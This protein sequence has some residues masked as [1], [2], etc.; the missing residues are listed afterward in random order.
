VSPSDFA[1]LYLGHSPV[2]AAYDE[3]VGS[4]A[5]PVMIL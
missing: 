2:T 5:G 3:F 1:K 4:G